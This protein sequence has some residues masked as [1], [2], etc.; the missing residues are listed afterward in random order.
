MAMITRTQNQTTSGC[1]I[2][3]E[4][5]QNKE[6]DKARQV[7]ELWCHHYFHTQFFAQ[8]I[9]VQERNL[10]SA[11]FRDEG[12]RCSYCNQ[13]YA[14]RGEATK[15]VLENQAHFMEA[16]KRIRQDYAYD[17]PA[18]KATFRLERLYSE[19]NTGYLTHSLTQNFVD[20]FVQLIKEK[21]EED[22]QADA[23]RVLGAML[24]QKGCLRSLEGEA[25]RWRGV[26]LE[27]YPERIK[28]EGVLVFFQD[29]RVRISA[30]YLHRISNEVLIE[31]T[32]DALKQHAEYIQSIPSRIAQK[33]YDFGAAIFSVSN[34]G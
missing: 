9:S 14:T 13:I 17:I 23:C 15:D 24:N 4:P 16:T 25:R 30:D 19:L 29:S 22:L 3:L 11:E 21:I 32:V 20:Y 18:V 10:H 6:Q 7:V 31:D 1:C 12:L 27:K 26:P 2:C 33:V 28:R 5:Y 34:S 8:A